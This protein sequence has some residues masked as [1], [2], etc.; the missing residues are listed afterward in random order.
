M[1]IAATTVAVITIILYVILF[2]SKDWS[3]FY[4]GYKYYDSSAYFEWTHL[5]D[6]GK[7]GQLFSGTGAAYYFYTRFRAHVLV[8]GGLA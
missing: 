3:I 7:P 4:K 6:Q 8:G 1:Y 2:L 5:N